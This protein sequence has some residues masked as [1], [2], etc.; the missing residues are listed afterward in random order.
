MHGFTLRTEHRAAAFATSY[1]LIPYRNIVELPVI[2]LGVLKL[3]VREGNL[4][5]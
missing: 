3:E 5:H 2:H 4:T 1:I